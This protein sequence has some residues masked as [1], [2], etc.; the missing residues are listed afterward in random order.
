[1]FSETLLDHARYPRNG[2]RMDSPDAVGHAD[3]GGSPPSTDIY[4]RIADGRVLAA[5]F[6]TFGCGVSVASCSAVTE[7]ATRKC[8]HEC[9]EI[10]SE[11]IVELLE[12]VPH[13]RRFCADLA[14][15]ALHDAIQKFQDTQK[16]SGFQ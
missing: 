13:D 3:R 15:L 12:G 6:T 14:V 10:R 5:K 7:L 9:L 16:P 11:H 4:L 1:M 2:G 8:L